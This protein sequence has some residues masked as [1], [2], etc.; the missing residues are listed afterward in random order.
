[1]NYKKDKQLIALALQLGIIKAGDFAR[2]MRSR[3]NLKRSK[4]ET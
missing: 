1:M 2:L 3:K 4:N